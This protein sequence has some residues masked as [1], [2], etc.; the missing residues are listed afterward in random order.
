MQLFIDSV[1]IAEI[2]KAASWRII[3]GATTNPTLIAK[4]KKDF[5]KTVLEICSIINGPVSAEAMSTESNKI[6]NEAKTISAWHKN[7]N[8]KIPCTFEGLKATAELK[9]LGIKTNLTLV[10][11][12]NQT[13]LAAKAGAT[14]ISVFVGRLD[15]A[16]ENG[17]Q[18]VKESM[19]VIKN[20]GFDSQ[21]IVASVRSPLTVQQTAILG[22]PI[23]TVPFKILEQMVKHPL[24]DTGIQ[25]FLEDWKK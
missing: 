22:T 15:D 6:V 17:I 23:A 2:K 1:N 7:I 9:Q 21:I 20:Y 8:I 10:F 3:S 11:S 14:Y 13:L 24:T 16:G 18:T 5:K 19:E 25:K 12:A 4:E